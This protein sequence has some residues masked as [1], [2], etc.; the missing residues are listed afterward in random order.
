M[1]I[2]LNKVKRGV[3]KLLSP[4]KKK[5]DFEGQKTEAKKT[6]E[7]ATRK[8]SSSSDSRSV[9]LKNDPSDEYALTNKLGRETF[10]KGL[11]GILEQYPLLEDGEG[12]RFF[13][14]PKGMSAKGV[15]REMVEFVMA[16]VKSTGFRFRW[17]GDISNAFSNIQMAEYRHKSTRVDNLLTLCDAFQNDPDFKA[18]K[19]SKE[20][21]SPKV[22]PRER[23]PTSNRPQTKSASASS[24][25]KQ[26]AEFVREFQEICKAH[27]QRTDEL[28]EQTYPVGPKGQLAMQKFLESEIQCPGFSQRWNK[29]IRSQ[30]RAVYAAL[31]ESRFIFKGWQDLRTSI[32][33]SPEF[34][35]MHLASP[36]GPESLGSTQR[37]RGGA[38]TNQK[39]TLLKYFENLKDFR[40]ELEFDDLMLAFVLGAKKNHP[41][42]PD[43]VFDDVITKMVSEHNI[44]TGENVSDKYALE[45]VKNYDL[46]VPEVASRS[47]IS[48]RNEK[49]FHPSEQ[50]RGF[51]NR[52]TLDNTPVRLS[53]VRSENRPDNSRGFDRRIK[54]A[55]GN[56]AD[57]V[58]YTPLDLE[59]PVGGFGLRPLAVG[60]QLSI[61]PLTSPGRNTYQ[62]PMNPSLN[63][64]PMQPYQQHQPNPQ[65]AQFGNNDN[66]SEETLFDRILAGAPK[67]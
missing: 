59:T 4:R 3:V 62:Q 33:N 61:S 19:A 58:R 45:A 30:F 15:T 60:L 14:V 66:T 43:S 35:K 40:S 13:S 38:T 65:G 48:G 55:S 5:K 47:N 27:D 34:Q 54:A 11:L 28:G 9:K 16:E 53:N 51:S 20:S 32:E 36:D 42:F 52:L 31:V 24:G 10:Y 7:R 39:S 6:F 12:G 37:Q 25:A 63:Q 56:S 18:W 49:D 57:I 22:N 67:Q 41:D 29:E 2:D 1:R 46:Q 21:R 23:R 50:S 8:S 26:L 44:S 64:Q 17:D